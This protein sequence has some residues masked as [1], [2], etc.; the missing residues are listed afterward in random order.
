M[1]KYNLWVEGLNIWESNIPLE[2]KIKKIEEI[3]IKIKLIPKD[4]KSPIWLNKDLT[5]IN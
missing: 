4:Y 1:Y 3:K 2:E 5:N